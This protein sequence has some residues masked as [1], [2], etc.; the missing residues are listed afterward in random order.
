MKTIGKRMVTLPTFYFATMTPKIQK[1]VAEGVDVI[2]LHIGSPDL[3]PP[4]AVVSN[5][6]GMDMGIIKGHRR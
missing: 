4:E 2:K 3:P 1:L 5:Q 6:T